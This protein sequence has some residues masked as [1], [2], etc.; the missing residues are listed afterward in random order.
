[1]D[2][3]EVVFGRIIEDYKNKRLAEKADRDKRVS[4]WKSV[5]QSADPLALV[6]DDAWKISSIPP[7]PGTQEVALGSH[8]SVDEKRLDPLMNDN[9]GLPLSVKIPHHMKQL[10]ADDF[11]INDPVFRELTELHQI[12]INKKLRRKEMLPVDRITADAIQQHVSLDDPLGTEEQYGAGGNYESDGS[13][14]DDYSS[15]YDSYSDEGAAGAG[16]ADGQG[17]DDHDGGA[18]PSDQ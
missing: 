2:I 6:S 8:L 12:Q 16:A 13:D 5:F 10:V 17:P 4:N 1:M 7:V 14:N 3:D 18:E 11:D 15:S 9:D